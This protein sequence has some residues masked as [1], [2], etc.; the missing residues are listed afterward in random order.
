[1]NSGPGHWNA[2]LDAAKAAE[3]KASTERTA[4]LAERFGVN[5]QHIRRIRA[6]LFWKLA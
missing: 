5:P 4:V 6:G 1:M 3:I 2:K